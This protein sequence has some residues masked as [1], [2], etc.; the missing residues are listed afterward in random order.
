MI[1]NAV[2][3]N[4]DHFAARLLSKKTFRL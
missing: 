3:F 2:N 1:A 4:S